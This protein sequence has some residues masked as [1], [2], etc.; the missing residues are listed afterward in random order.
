MQRDAWM[1]GPE[2]QASTQSGIFVV[3]PNPSLA[4]QASCTHPRAEELANHRVKFQL[5][6]APSGAGPIR[7]RNFGS[8]RSGGLQAAVYR[9]KGSKEEDF[10][11]EPKAT[12][13]Q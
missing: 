3:L 10:G 2:A 1:K 11:L 5:S 8:R 7:E 12:S 6:G 4:L 13:A 9:A